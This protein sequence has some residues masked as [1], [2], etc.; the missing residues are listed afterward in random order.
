MVRADVG[1][2]PRLVQGGQLRRQADQR[3]DEEYLLELFRPIAAGHQQMTNLVLRIEQH[4]ADGIERIGLAQAVDHGA[5]QLRQ[6]VGPQQRQ[7]ARL[8]ALQDGFV[9]GRLG[10]QLRRRFLSASFSWMMSSML[11]QPSAR[12]RLGA[13]R[14]NRRA[15][16]S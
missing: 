6:A 10:R 2:E 5:Q 3:I 11:W 13:A 7:F 14:R 16:D 9:V 15:L 1:T 12:A 4:H 8:G